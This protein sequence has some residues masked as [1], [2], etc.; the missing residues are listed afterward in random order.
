[1]NYL[2]SIYDESH[3]ENNQ[4]IESTRKM[5]NVL[6]KYI[7]EYRNTK[8]VIPLIA[9]NICPV[10]RNIR[11]QKGERE[12]DRIEDVSI[13]KIAYNNF[14]HFVSDLNYGNW[15]ELQ[16]EILQ[17]GEESDW[18]DQSVLKTNIAI[19]RIKSEDA[20]GCSR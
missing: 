7:V 2:Y 10:Q 8:N 4:Y 17:T 15:A 6:N 3:G 13:I 18:V 14:E 16:E 19:D 12:A 1:M 5:K 20:G 11:M 9:Y